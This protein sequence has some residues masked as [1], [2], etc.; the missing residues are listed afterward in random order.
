MDDFQIRSLGPGTVDSP[1]AE[2]SFFVG[3]HARVRLDVT[4]DDVRNGGGAS[5]MLE[6]A[7]PRR[8]NFFGS[9]ARAAIVTCGGL[10]PGINDVIR[11]ITMVLWYRYGI[12]DI[13]GLR[14]GYQGLLARGGHDPIPLT[15]EVVE[16]IHKD[17]G[18]ILGTSRGPQDPREQVDFL[19]A[20]GINILFAI[21]GDGTQRGALDL[22]REAARR[23]L[24]IAVIGVPKTIDNDLLYTQRT[25]GF[26]TAVAMSEIPIGCVHMEAKAV[27]NGIGLVKLMGRD[28]GFVAAYAT[29]ASSDVNVVLVP[30][31]PFSLPRL[32]AFLEERLARKS[33]A[34]IVVAEGVGQN[35]VEARGVDASG[36]RQFGDIGLLLKDEITKHFRTRGR[37]VNVKYIDPSYMIRSAPA[38]AEDSVF[39][40][41]LGQNAVHAAMS[42]R[43]EMV[44]GL[45]NGCYVHVPIAKAVEFRKTIDISGELWQSVMDNTGQPDLG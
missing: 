31:A 9:D 5:V 13:L 7:G 17:G 14:Y 34:V 21:G 24:P 45:W 38:T 25:F 29:L 15:P 4:V 28:S 27:E 44:I 10:C 20:R 33:H 18:T 6:K 40:F 36:N 26:V 8:K 41:Q 32:L 2:S 43:T 22:S 42:G 19:Q 16:D 12:R 37:G 30:E 11:A 35:L 1:L 3:D 39:C 23:G